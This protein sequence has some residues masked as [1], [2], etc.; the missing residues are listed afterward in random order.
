[1]NIVALCL[2]VAF[3][4]GIAPI[5]E[6]MSLSDASSFTVLT[7]RSIATTVVLIVLTVI[8][9]KQQE[10]MAVDG[11]T[12]LL[13][14]AGGFFG[15]LGLFIYFVALK[16]DLAT[17]VVP[18]VNIFPLFTALNAVIILNERLTT[19]RTAGIV[20]VVAGVV[21]INWGQFTAGHAD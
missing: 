1:M 15:I 12:F 2:L 13:I 6:K 20:L 7:I 10:V 17:R 18:L 14:L 5:L 21:L 19:Q 9:G 4:W 11:K 16:Q 3:L 8:T